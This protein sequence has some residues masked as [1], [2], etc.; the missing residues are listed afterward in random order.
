MPDVPTPPSNGSPG[1]SSDDLTL[2]IRNVSARPIE[3]SSTV[4]LTIETTRGFVRGLLDPAEGET[5]AVVY[6]DGAMA[7]PHEVLGPGERSY[8]ALA[9][10]LA[11]QGVTSLRIHYRHAGELEESVLDVLAACSFL[12]GI[13][14]RSVALVGHSFGGAVVIK[15]GEL[16]PI[17]VAVASLSPQLHGTRQVEK[18]GKPLLLIHGD[19]DHVLSH[20]ASED[21]F[22]RAQDPKRLVLLEGSGHA[23]RQGAAELIEELEPYLLEAVGPRSE[24]NG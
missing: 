19:A 7:G 14:A 21:I 12:Q 11:P 18:L 13:G 24:A 5:G 10:R 23:L 1:H 6:C 22:A 4:E 17:V 16:A 2:G 20:E 9:Q 8:E 15:A 3:G